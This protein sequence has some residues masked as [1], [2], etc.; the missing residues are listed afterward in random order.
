[1]T[2]CLG[3]KLVKRKTRSEQAEDSKDQVIVN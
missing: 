3:L 2:H 1:M